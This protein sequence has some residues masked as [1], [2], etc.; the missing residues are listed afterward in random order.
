MRKRIIIMGAAGRDFHVFNTCYRNK[1]SCNVVAF[2]AAQIPNIEGRKYPPILSGRYYP[3][4]IPIHKESEL[5]KTIRNNNINEVIFA[6]SDV[7]YSYIKERELLVK[8]AGANFE[9]FDIKPTFIN[10]VKPV[11]AV[12]AVRT[13][14]GKS[15]I[16]RKIAEILRKQGKNVVVIRHPMPY[17]DLTKQ[18]VQRFASLE[19]LQR[20]NC[21]IE[22]MEEY[23]PHI[24]GGI[25][26][27]SGIDY[28]KILKAAENE[29][30]VIIWDGGNNDLPYIKPDLHIT[31]VDPLRAGDEI[32]YFPGKINLEMADIIII[33]KINAAKAEQ[34]AI[35]KNNIK[36]FNPSATIFEAKSII[37]V[38]DE[39]LIRDKNVVV[40]EDGPTVTHGGMA[41]GA[42]IMAAYQF[43]ARRIVDPRPYATGTIKEIYQ[44]YPNIGK[45]LPAVGYSVQQIEDLRHTIDA[46][47][48]DIVLIA[49][50]IDLSRLIRIDKKCVKVSYEA[51]AD[52]EKLLRENNKWQKGN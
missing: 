31:I 1:S 29:A 40:I 7:S 2:T 13:G 5:I 16:S 35:V 34:L 45:L 6:Y 41:Y 42:G 19:D 27:Y 49:T 15:P 33:N 32:N 30:D 36:K 47:P 18:I 25:I 46:I 22:E 12:C 37:N 51:K 26:V 9:T 4:G 48:A 52:F 44:Q 10:S 3:K 23:E 21:T 17:G 8:K 14:A 38:S 11:I 43:G 50:P 39:K 28:E 24:N 20:Q